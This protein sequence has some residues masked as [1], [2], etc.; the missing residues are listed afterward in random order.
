MVRIGAM[1]VI[2]LDIPD[3][4]VLHPRVFEDQR[5]FFYE[6][7]V[8]PTLAE[9]GIADVFVQDNHSL[10]RQVGVIRGLHFQSPP[11]AQAKIVRCVRGAILDVAVDIRVNSPTFGRHVSQVLSAENKR[12][13]YVPIGFAH[14]FS[15]LEPDSEV[16]YKC[17]DIFAPDLEGG[18]RFDDPDLAIDWKIDPDDVVISEKDEQWPLLGELT[19][20]FQFTDWL[21]AI[22][23]KRGRGS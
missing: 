12:M 8:Q 18:V 16:L 6:S 17:S 21:E 1:K 3:V 5:G 4:L 20:P 14:G 9:H 11:A 2:Q 15:V 23:V 7:Y 22:G 13:M 10:S 19:S